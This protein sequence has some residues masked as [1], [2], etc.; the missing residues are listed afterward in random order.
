MDIGVSLSKQSAVCALS[1]DVGRIRPRTVKFN[2][3]DQEKDKMATDI[4]AGIDCLLWIDKHMNKKKK[5][6]RK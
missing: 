6:A 2:S 3:Q 4:T 1:F 5:D